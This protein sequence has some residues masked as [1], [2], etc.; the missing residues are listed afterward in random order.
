MAPPRTSSSHSAFPIPTAP[1]VTIATLFLNFSIGS[2][3]SGF[4]RARFF[5]GAQTERSQHCEQVRP[6]LSAGAPS[7]PQ[8]RV[9]N[10]RATDEVHQKIRIGTLGNKPLITRPFQQTPDYFAARDHVVVPINRH[11]FRATRN[12]A[13]QPRGHLL[14]V[15]PS[16]HLCERIDEQVRQSS[17]RNSFCYCV[18]LR[19]PPRR[20]DRL[21]DEFFL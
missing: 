14:V 20:S 12:G 18:L 1:P 8:Q 6:H 3:S 5:L 15:R 17:Q 2:P 11:E 16:E 7:G 10:D 13:N 21:R 19:S 4:V 9:M